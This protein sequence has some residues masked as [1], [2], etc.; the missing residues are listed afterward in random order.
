[1]TTCAACGSELA[2]DARYCCDCG[3]RLEAGHM[4]S[5]ARTQ[6]CLRLLDV[7]Y[8]LGLV[9]YKKGNFDQ[10]LVAWRRA[11]EL[12]PDNEDIRLRIAEAEV[13]IA[14]AST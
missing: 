13:R 11:E 1:M 4:D 6:K 2:E 5:G 9:Y 7:H 14:L 3:Q 8:N 12:E 10:A